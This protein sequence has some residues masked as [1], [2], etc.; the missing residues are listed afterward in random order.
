MR[1]PE[2]ARRFAPGQDSAGVAPAGAFV[3]RFDQWPKA[4]RRALLGDPEEIANLAPAVTLLPA[5][6][7]HRG[8]AVRYR[9]SKA[10]QEVQVAGRPAVGEAACLPQCGQRAV[11]GLLGLSVRVGGD[12]VGSLP[13]HTDRIAC[14]IDELL[15]AAPGR[16]SPTPATSRSVIGDRGLADGA[17]GRH[18]GAGKSAVPTPNANRLTSES[19]PTTRR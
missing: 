3:V 2:V 16:R 17:D 18:E 19:L 5:T 11:Q 1:T 7:H 9:R 4:T 12:V 10:G 6:C 15:R 13:T 14:R 8:E